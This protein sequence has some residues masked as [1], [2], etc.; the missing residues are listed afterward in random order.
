M[1]PYLVLLLTIGVGCAMSSSSASELRPVPTKAEMA[2]ARDWIAKS[3]TPAR[4][5]RIPIS[6][7]YDGKSSSALLPEWKFSESK[8][9]LTSK[10]TQ[11]TRTY[12]DPATGLQL[13]VVLVEYSD[14]PTVEWTAYFKNTGSEDTPILE[15]IQ[16]LNI[17]LQR[18]EAQGEFTLRS[19]QGS[20]TTA[21]DFQPFITTLGPGSSNSIKT[22]GG[23]PMLGVMPYFNLQYGDQGLIIAIA[24]TGQWAS[25]WTRDDGR[26]LEVS[27][28]QET[29]HFVL[30]PGEEVRTP[31]I[32]LQF[33]KAPSASLLQ[34]SIAG[35]TRKQPSALVPNDAVIR[36]Q[37]IWRRWMI[38][39]SLPRPGGKP[40]PP[41]TSVCCLDF[42]DGAKEEIMYLN[43]YKDKGIWASYWWRDAGWYPCKNNW[44]LTGNWEVDKSRYPNGMKE[45]VDAA[46]ANGMKFTMWFEP[47]RAVAPSW[48]TENHPEWMLKLPGESVQLVDL[49]NEEARN[50]VLNFVDKT[51]TENGV[52]MYRQDFNMS[53]LPW[54]Q[55]NDT[56]D[57]QGMTENKHVQGL[58]W[59]WDELKKRHPK[60]PFDNCAS[61]GHRNDLEM[62]R[63]GFPLSRTDYCGT[64]VPSQAQTWG[65]AQWLPYFAAGSGGDHSNLYVLRSNLA[66]WSAWVWDARKPDLDYKTIR[67]HLSEVPKV[68]PYFWGDF[69]PLTPYSLDDKVWMAWQFNLPEKGTGM[70]QAFRRAESDDESETYRLHDLDPKATY[71]LTDLDAPGKTVMTGEEL[72]SR[73]LT[74]KAKDKPYAAII[75]YRKSR[76]PLCK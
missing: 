61:G 18:D 76:Q 11:R 17:Q 58:Y 65:L 26:T 32:V 15:R 48:I 9:K 16:A 55:K 69:Y 5:G 20:L 21:E 66:P 39:H 59:W 34:A 56:E 40:M 2:I 75:T 30:H 62:M 68:Q 7:V 57:R 41:E 51:I 64:D 1:N 29:T 25:T 74:I 42:N 71:V 27:A 60:M 72:M 49:G 70:I 67:K 14:F 63:R 8:K 31:L 37:N 47:E 10:K 44:W 23:C 19:N 28:G 53:P 46:H 3:F 4:N 36:A 6:F 33:W 43:A 38:A 13:R 52:D 50:W 54:W 22:S 73:G 24:W 35:G 45:V 12:T